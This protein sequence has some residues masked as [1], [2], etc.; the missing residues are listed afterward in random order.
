MDT[1]TFHNLHQKVRLIVNRK[2]T[3]SLSQK[4]P[5][6]TCLSCSPFKDSGHPDSL[7]NIPL[8]NF[9]EPLIICLLLFMSSQKG[10]H[11]PKY[12]RTSWDFVPAARGE[13]WQSHPALNTKLTLESFLWFFYR[14]PVSKKIPTSSKAIRCMDPLTI[15]VTRYQTDVQRSRF[16]TLGKLTPAQ[17]VG[18]PA[19]GG[20]ARTSLRRSTHRA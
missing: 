10:H 11:T 15:Q 4:R 1:A 20:C 6:M 8:E 2:K 5:I 9:S 19:I 16:D 12:F 7:L 18:L 3:A 17:R 13:V 14:G